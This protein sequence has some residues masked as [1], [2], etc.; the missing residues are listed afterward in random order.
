MKHPKIVFFSIIT[1]LLISFS[2]YRYISVK[3][4]QPRYTPTT[5]Q[6]ASEGFKP[7]GWLDRKAATEQAINGDPN[8]GSNSYKAGDKYSYNQNNPNAN[9]Q[10]Q[11]APTFPSKQQSDQVIQPIKKN[12]KS[13]TFNNAGAYIVNNNKP[14]IGKVKP[15]GRPWAQNHTQML[16]KKP[17]EADAYLTRQARQ[18]QNRVQTG[19]GA[20]KWKPAGYIQRSNLSQ[21]YPYAYNRG[22][23]LGY[24][25][26]GN[27]KKFNASESNPQN[28][29]TQTMWANQAG[30]PNNTGQNYYEGVVRQGLDQNK[31]IRYKVIP[32]YASRLEKIPRAIQLEAKSSDNTIQ[33]NVLVPN[34]QSNINIDYHSGKT[35]PI[36]Y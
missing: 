23:L 14:N 21:P 35:T 12:F 8:A 22:H 10:P 31:T 13:L 29:V 2:G 28:I 26:V 16:S 27:I 17:Q 24:A 15:N 34:D 30:A 11:N 1:L 3:S 18:Y 20:S 5:I 9:S 36:N 25:I 33:F 6:K 7:A 19:N 4:N 32:W